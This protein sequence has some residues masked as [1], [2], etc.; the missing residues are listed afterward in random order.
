MKERDSRIELQSRGGVRAALT[1]V[2]NPFMRQAAKS[3]AFGYGKEPLFVGGGGTIGSIPEFQRVF[4]EAPVVML[5]M[6]LLSDGYHAP[7]ERFSLSQAGNG[8]KVMANY[9]NSIANLR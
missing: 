7:N 8:I 6:S 4:P 2:D 1:T 3:C 9:L 5:A